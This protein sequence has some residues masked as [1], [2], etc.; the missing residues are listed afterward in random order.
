MIGTVKL[1]GTVET[2][3]LQSKVLQGNLP[4]DAT[5][6]MLPV[7]LPPGYASSTERYPVIYVLS[8]QQQRP[9]DAEFA[10][11]GESFRNG[12]TA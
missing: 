7:Y 6:R 12:S 10:G 9:A 3:W 5:E 4:G 1:Q 8:G 2:P 11:V